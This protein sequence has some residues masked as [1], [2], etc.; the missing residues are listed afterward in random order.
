MINISDCIPTLAA[1][2]RRTAPKRSGAATPAALQ[3]MADYLDAC[4]Y[5]RVI[6][7]LYD[8]ILDYGAREIEGLNTRGLFIRGTCGI[9]KTLGVSCLAARFGWPVIQAKQLQAAFLSA[10]SDDAFWR[11]VDAYDF[12]DKPQTLVIDDIGTESC[13]V[14]KYGTATNI[15]ADVLDRRYFMGWQRHGVRTIITSNLS[16][17]DLCERYG[18]RSEDRMNEMFEF[19]TATGDSLRK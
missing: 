8:N 4:G 17:T 7:K 15:I 2:Q 10:E 6:P 5:T 19:V 1:I 16:D 3:E 13:P 14:M 18:L 9:G 11:I 12:F